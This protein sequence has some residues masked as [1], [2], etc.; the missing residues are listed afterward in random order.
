MRKIP[1][2]V[3]LMPIVPIVNSHKDSLPFDIQDIPGSRGKV[4]FKIYDWPEPYILFCRKGL[5]TLVF[6]TGERIRRSVS[7]MTTYF[8]ERFGKEVGDRIPLLFQNKF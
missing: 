7:L 2:V 6:P 1:T 8:T 5:I 4:S 3:R